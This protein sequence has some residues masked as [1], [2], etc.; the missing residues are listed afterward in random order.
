[1]S[2]YIFK[3]DGVLMSITDLDAY[4]NIQ[5][6]KENIEKVYSTNYYWHIINLCLNQ[7]ISEKYLSGDIYDKEDEIRLTL[8][9]IKEFLISNFDVKDTDEL[10][11]KVTSILFSEIEDFKL[12]INKISIW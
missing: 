4:L 8:K 9:K 11:K 12:I 7:L 3:E 5:I 2:S 6:D 10:E 1:M